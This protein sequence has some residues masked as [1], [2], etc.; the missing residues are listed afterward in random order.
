MIKP[1]GGPW[2]VISP[3]SVHRGKTYSDLISD[4]FNWLL[5]ADPDKH[6]TGPV[7][8]LRAVQIP[9]SGVKPAI[10]DD[11]GS[12][13]GSGKGFDLN[14][15]NSYADD[16]YFPRR[17]PN[18]PNVMMG[19]ERLQITKDQ[20][21]FVPIIVAYAESSKPYIDWGQMQEYNGVT[22]DNGDNPPKEDQL[23]ID[24]D[25]VINDEDMPAHR[26]STPIFTAVVPETDF[27][28]SA[29]DFLEMY[30]RPGQYPVMVEGYFAL[31]KFEEAGRYQLHSRAKAGRE[32]HGPYFAELL[33]EVEVFDKNDPAIRPAR[34][35]AIIGAI[36]QT[37]IKKGE[38]D[39]KKGKDLAK[40]MKLPVSESKNE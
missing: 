11:T 30:F 18:N 2:N 1:K 17:Y 26:I 19:G 37:K 16:A 20:A 31:I 38:V 24:G 7:A 4:W 28:R 35:E 40:K 32:T 25:P 14:V 5:T 27:G 21:I 39:A 12:S 22:I 3:D 34:N 23:T 29:K 33:Y 8:F 13:E 9:T 15:S 10:D 6:N 36:L